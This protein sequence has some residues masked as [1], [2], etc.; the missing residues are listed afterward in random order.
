MAWSAATL[1]W[2]AAGLLVLAE[3]ATGTFYL[4]MLALGLVGA[5]LAAHAGFGLSAQLLVAA[6]V[7]GGA[8]MAW[9]QRKLSTSTSLEPS[10][11]PDIQQDLGGRV[12]VSQWSEDGR[13]SVNYRG[14]AWSARRADASSARTGPHRIVAV[15]GNVLVLAPAADP[16]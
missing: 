7:G 11:N 12:T 10:V 3:L 9:R 2:A 16:A 5:A 14:A 13:C 15:E 6:V 1:W 4:L 8:V